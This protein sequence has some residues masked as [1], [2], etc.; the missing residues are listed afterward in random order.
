MC[1]GNSVRAMHNAENKI[2]NLSF[3]KELAI[4]SPFYFNGSTKESA[5]RLGRWP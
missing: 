1:P 5:E 2:K 3:L 4:W